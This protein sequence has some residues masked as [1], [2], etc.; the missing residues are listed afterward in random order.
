MSTSIRAIMLFVGCLVA[1]GALWVVSAS[2]LYLWSVGPRFDLFVFPY[3]QW[4]EVVPFWD[5]TPWMRVY[6]IGSAA[7]PTIA[8]AL[9]VCG[10][11]RRRFKR[12]RLR[13]PRAG[14]LRPTKPGVTDN[15]GHSAW[16]TPE[17]LSAR[18]SGQ[19]CLIGAADRS[20]R[21]PLLFDPVSSGPT[22][23]LVISGPGSHKTS[24]AITRIW[25]WR[26][27]RVVFDPS[28]EIGPIMTPALDRAGYNVTSIGINGAGIDALDWIDPDHPEADSHIRA[29]CDW[30]YNEGA[31]IRGN[32]GHAKDPFWDTWGRALVV[33]LAAHMIYSDDATLPKTFATLRRGIATPELDMRTM[34][35]G[36]N[37]TS[38]S[39]MARDLAGGLMGMHAADTFSGIYANSFAATEWLSVGAY[40]DIVSGSAMRT[41]DILDSKTVVFIQL[42]L[43]TLQTTPAVGRAIMGAFFNAMFHADGGGIDD[44]ILFLIDE[45]WVLGAMKE[46]KLCHTTARKYRGSLCQ[47]FQSEGQ[48]EGIW[49][50]DDAKLMRDTV[51]WRSY[52]AIQD[53]DVAEKLSRDLGEHAVLAF[54]E[55]TN[56]GKQR[57]AMAW[58]GSSSRG[59]N[60]NTH[61]IKRRLIKADEI[62]RAP[63]DEMWL[64]ARDFPYPIRCATA[65]YFRYPDLA[66]TMAGNRFANVAAQ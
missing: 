1:T 23:S 39:G 66:R 34:L 26:G 53:G 35:T 31:A 3:D 61:E 57:Q 46:I 50:R 4:I 18:F 51:S 54:S 19:G 29:A 59:D 2:W 44:R 47:L 27:A 38:K 6:V 33:C 28:C 65:P 20:A 32:G 7:V 64:L 15:H 17:Q 13:R 43:R 52:N 30:I 8:L 24:S 22:H 12:S 14:G 48:L 56:T 58:M 10:I 40:A 42:P 37:R 55:G 16:A 5:A 21:S 9:I 45:A 11:C 49:G 36:I 41:A 62:M 25:H 63:A 60:L